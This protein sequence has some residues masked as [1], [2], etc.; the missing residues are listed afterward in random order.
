MKENFEKCSLGKFICDKIHDLHS[1]GMLIMFSSQE[2]DGK[3]EGN[4]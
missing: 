3:R 4:P 2:N 1:K